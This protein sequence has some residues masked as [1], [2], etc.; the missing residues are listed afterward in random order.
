[1]TKLPDRKIEPLTP[2]P[3]S[4]DQVV[5]AAHA[6]RR[7]R[8]AIV[9]SS[10]AVLALVAGTSFA[11]GSS[12]RVTQRIIDSAVSVVDRGPSPQGS[13]PAATNQASPT[14]HKKSKKPAAPSTV[15]GGAGLGATGTVE[16]TTPQAISYLRGRAVDAAGNPV[17]DLLVLP[18]QT[19]HATFVSAGTVA[20]TTDEAGNFK[21]PCP[22][23]PV[24]LATWALG[25]E[26]SSPL[27]GRDWSATFVGGSPTKAVVPSCG[28]H[29][30]TVTMVQ[31]STLTGTVQ[32]TGSC[33]EATFPL[34]VWLGGDR[35]NTV[36]INGLRDGDV[37]RVSGLPAGTHVLGQQRVTSRL[38]L[39][40]GAALEQN[41][42]F[43]CPGI[44][45]DEP[46]GPT[47]GP[48]TEPPTVTATPTATPTGG[49]TSTTSAPS[50]PPTP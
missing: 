10:V 15:A 38:D 37:Y 1:M 32:V 19:D 8:G 21:I 11:L 5:K 18:G 33:P 39:P 47:G 35:S 16:A 29:R 2:P 12:M 4:F 22:H 14:R 27:I 7:R 49:P 9:T 23:A 45:T 48:T 30:T 26:Q 6:R 43:T 40:P 24:M 28:K 25:E 3:G 41:A 50:S 44:P 31:G 20:D 34:R 13:T 46:T 36:R 42:R 17:P